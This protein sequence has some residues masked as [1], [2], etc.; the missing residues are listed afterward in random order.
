MKQQ[1][2]GVLRVI[3]PLVRGSNPAL[4]N[5]MVILHKPKTP[6]PKVGLRSM[7]K[8]SKTFLSNL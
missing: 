7:N 6:S 4:G 8:V 2:N 3:S 1:K 5:V